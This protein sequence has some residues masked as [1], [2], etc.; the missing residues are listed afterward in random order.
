[1]NGNLA[2]TER[3]SVA[4]WYMREHGVADDPAGTKKLAF[5]SWLYAL[6]FATL[7]TS[8][9]IAETGSVTL[10]VIPGYSIHLTRPK[11]GSGADLKITSSALPSPLVKHLNAP[12]LR[13]MVI[14]LGEAMYR[15]ET[16]EP[17][18]LLKEF[19]FDKLSY[20]RGNKPEGLEW[21]T[22]GGAPIA[23]IDL[24]TRGGKPL[25]QRSFFANECDPCLACGLPIYR[26]YKR[27]CDTRWSFDTIRLLPK[28]KVCYE[29]STQVYTYR[30]GLCGSDVTLTPHAHMCASGPGTHATVMRIEGPAPIRRHPMWGSLELVQDKASHTL[31]AACAPAVPRYMYCNDGRAT[32]WQRLAF[33]SRW[34]HSIIGRRK[35]RPSA[36]LAGHI[37]S[38]AD[39]I[40]DRILAHIRDSIHPPSH[41]WIS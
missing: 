36:L 23:D 30:C 2:R 16:K 9:T 11:T 21:T 28:V 14:A 15:P 22:N 3:E 40:I 38:F 6:E 7:A 32:P 8:P 39:H 41:R 34:A 18:D 5:C 24:L 26:W 31:V 4:A 10:T 19:D 35:L 1:M 33:I 27:S 37:D 13:E 29:C 17:L 20:V 25:H 12:T